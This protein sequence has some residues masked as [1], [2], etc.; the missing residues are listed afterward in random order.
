MGR[1]F[2]TDKFRHGSLASSN[3]GPEHE[4]VA[5]A[6]RPNARPVGRSI[7]TNVE[8]DGS[9]RFLVLAVLTTCCLARMQEPGERNRGNRHWYSN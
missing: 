8:I 5:F 6:T 3:H 7:K 2:A 9:F 1:K 4:S